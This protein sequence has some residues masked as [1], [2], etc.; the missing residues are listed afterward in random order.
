MRKAMTTQAAIQEEILR[1]LG[2]C[3]GERCHCTVP[4]IRKCDGSSAGSN[5]T[6][7]T[8]QGVAAR[9]LPCFTASMLSVMRDFDLA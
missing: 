3:G 6:V 9:C 4:P 5:W 8:L 7:D 2:S 1:R